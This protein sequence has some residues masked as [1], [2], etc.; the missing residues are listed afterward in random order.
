MGEEMQISSPF[1]VAI[2]DGGRVK[3]IWSVDRWLIKC[4]KALFKGFGQRLRCGFGVDC[5]R[6][7]ESRF[8]DNRRVRTGSEGDRG[9]IVVGMVNYGG[10]QGRMG[11]GVELI[12]G[13]RDA[14]RGS[15]SEQ[16]EGPQVVGRLWL[17]ASRWF[18]RMR[19]SFM[20]AACL[21]EDGRGG[22]VFL[23]SNSF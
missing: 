12:A 3:E 11:R 7:A 5:M 19:L 15:G 21:G 9:G 6:V 16:E 13:A 1:F 2:G 4:S 8:P 20:I 17:G 10:L 14:L 18:L 22:M 23:W